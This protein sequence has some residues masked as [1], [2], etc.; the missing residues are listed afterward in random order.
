MEERRP[1]F[2]FM[3]LEIW[4]DAIDLGSRLFDLAD[5]LELKKLFRFADISCA[6]LDYRCPII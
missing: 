4:H 5:E 6:V 1:K 3:D 2:R